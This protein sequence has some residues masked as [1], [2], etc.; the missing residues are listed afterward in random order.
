MIA[1]L[2]KRRRMEPE[3]PAVL[4]G[5]QRRAEQIRRA[6]IKERDL[7]RRRQRQ[8]RGR[9]S[10][11]TLR[12]TEL[13]RLYYTRYKGNLLPDDDDG[14]DSVQIMVNHLA[15]LADP[16]LRIA[17]WLRRCAPWLPESEAKPLIE[18][19]IGRPRRWQADTLAR[20]LNLTDAERSRLEIR[21]VGAVDLNRQQRQARR[22]EKDKKAK[23]AKRRAAGAIPRAKSISHTKP[24]LAIGI[25]R[26]KWYKDRQKAP[27]IFASR[28]RG[29]FRRQYE[30]GVTVDEFVQTSVGP[31]AP[32]GQRR[33]SG[34]P[35]AQQSPLGRPLELGRSLDAGRNA[36]SRA[37]ITP[38][39][40][41]RNAESWAEIRQLRADILRSRACRNTSSERSR[42]SQR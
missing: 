9:P 29:Q 22:R 18:A 5:E 3:D 15:M 25:G 28:D 2:A 16:C 34:S 13:N 23:E 38:D 41:Q 21:T 42:P 4:A 27:D 7:E 33:R 40:R 6:Y 24:W 10:M 8:K 1:L 20:R 36:P 11:A 30:A 32:D 35:A 19:A 37:A 17:H 26:S 14:R 39:W 12:V 31:A